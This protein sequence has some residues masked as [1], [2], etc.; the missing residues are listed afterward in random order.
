[1]ESNNQVVVGLSCAQLPPP[2]DNLL[3]SSVDAAW[4]SRPD[5]ARDHVA[6]VEHLVKNGSGEPRVD[7]PYGTAK[8]R[9]TIFQDPVPIGDPGHPDTWPCYEDEPPPFPPPWPSEQSRRAMQAESAH[10]HP[11]TPLGPLAKKWVQDL[12]AWYTRLQK[13]FNF[14]PADLPAN[15]RRNIRKWE[16]RLSFLRADHPLLYEAIIASIR[17]GH[18]IPFAK[19]PKKFF[20]SRNPPSLAADKIRAWVAIKKDLAHGALRPVDLKADGTPH[21]VCPVRTA[22]K[23]DGSARFVHNSRR[24]NK[25]VLPEAT[26]CKLETLLKARNIF[27]PNGFLVGLDFASGYH[28]LS[29]HE[30]DRKYLAFALDESELTEEAVAWL[31]ANHPNCYHKARRCFVFEYLALPFGLSS[32]CRTFNDLVTALMAF[33]RRCPVDGAPTRVSSYIDDVHGVTA[34]FD[35]AMKLSI[36]MVYEAASLGLSLKIPKCSFFPRHAMRALGTIVDLKA[37]KFS[38][39]RSRAAKVCVARRK[40]RAEVEQNWNAVPAKSVASFIGLIWSIASCCHRAASIMVRSIT[41]TLSV[42]LKQC[43]DIFQMPLSRIINRFWSGSVRWSVAADRQLRFWERVCF[44]GLSAPI[45][46]D[47]LGLA[48]E[49]S[50]WYPA[51]LNAQDVS[52]LFQDASGTASGGGVLHLVNGVLQPMGDIFLA[53]FSEL[54]RRLSSTLRELLGMLWC[55]RA[56]SD[57]TKFRLVFICDNL[58]SCRAVLRGSRV[59]EIQWVAEQIFLW[60]LANNKVCWPVWVPRTHRLIKVADTRSRLSIPHDDRSPRAV[61]AAAN[62]LAVSLWGSGLSFDQAASHMSAVKVNGSTLPFNAFCFQPGAS[63][64]D[65]FRCLHSWRCNI[66]Y[67]FPPEP[68]TGRLLSFLPSTR[69][70]SVVALRLPIRNAWWTYTVQPHSAGLLATRRV[71]GFKIFAFDFSTQPEGAGCAGPL[72]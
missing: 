54:Q 23:N 53:E 62:K 1:M 46:A 25:C 57:E 71:A 69:A 21:C 67:V 39:T 49:R 41:A 19:K 51:D 26:R 11:E 34:R 2:P 56:T 36:L 58:Q 38:V 22:D 33:W 30:D 8:Q 43:A 31:H 64:I 44:V 4:M 50:F 42:G 60:C 16:K 40:L 15:L 13:H 28:C 9:R 3:D 45:S 35:S 20:R 70:K 47:V 55:V 61:V 29:M 18:K 10:L 65:M 17:V 27:I 52:F 7:K 14:D 68:M 37:F 48:V 12:Q 6:A 24:V 72:Y 63:G 32:S 5:N 59:P 66:N